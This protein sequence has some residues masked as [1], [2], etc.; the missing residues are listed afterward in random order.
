MKTILLVDDEPEVVQTMVRALSRSSKDF[1]ILTASNGAEAMTILEREPVDLI[2]TDLNMPVMNGFHL[3]V[4]ILK[5][6]PTTPVIVLT[7]F[8]ISTM[9]ARLSQRGF[10]SITYIQKPFSVKYFAATIREQLDHETHGHIE[11]I[12]L[13]N[14]LQ[15][16]QLEQKTCT[17]RIYAA[18]G[19]GN[20]TFT[21]GELIHAWCNNLIGS[22]A[23]YVIM[24]WSDV[25][26]DLRDLPV[27]PQ[28][29]IT[30]PL[31]QLLLESVRRHDETAPTAPP[32]DDTDPVGGPTGLWLPMPD[33][34]QDDQ[35]PAALTADAASVPEA[36][37]VPDDLVLS[38][39]AERKDI[40]M[41][42]V[43]QSLD[44]A[45]TIDGALGVALVDYQSGMALGMA[46][47]SATLNLEVAAAGNTDVVRAKMKVMTSLG[48]KDS[49]EDILITLGGQYH[50]IR[51]LSSSPGL[52]L[53]LVL[54]KAQSN[55]AM[56]RHK[57]AMIETNLAV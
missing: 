10:S 8:D 53:Y 35:L 22:E 38:N 25:R 18:Q 32:I 4:Y 6:C 29:T 23:A 28:R 37:R 15:L 21:N 19:E 9:Q 13:F 50:L 57:L 31:S 20:L 17:L 45:M 51:L 46:G 11:G 48:L 5:Q 34:P 36:G 52:F 43:K 55:L 14:I 42:N 2:S 1:T 41:S 33:D 40:L 7:A 3:L 30:T 27:V 47:G 12:S 26:I 54:S 39:P 24:T 49:I 56:S 16:F 44:E